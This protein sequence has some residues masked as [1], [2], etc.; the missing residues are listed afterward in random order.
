MAEALRDGPTNDGLMQRFQVLVYPDPLP[1]WKNIDRPPNAKAIQ[2]AE[3][4]YRYLV[5][6]GAPQALRLR[7]APDGQLLF[8]AWLEAH[9]NSLHSEDVHPALK[10]HLTKYRSLMPS[11]ALLFELADEGM[12][13]VSLK[14]AQQAAAFC[15]HLQEHAHRIYSMVGPAT[16]RSANELAH[17]LS[18]GGRHE[19]GFFTAREVYRHG[20]LKLST[21]EE[22][23]GA[24][25]IL[26]DAKWI[27]RDDW[28]DRERRNGGRPTE[29]Y[30]IN[31]K[32]PQGKG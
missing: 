12:T 16:V 19:E 4:T 17:R 10:S 15:E 3:K 13:A 20:W 23:C 28:A 11:L 18:A 1:E 9:E 7:F 6:L 24:M 26:T 22:A 29:R 2:E 21:P 31:P 30:L 8:N 5:K 14:H 25:S 27:R 32:I